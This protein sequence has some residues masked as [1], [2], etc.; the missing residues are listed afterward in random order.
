M[1][2]QHTNDGLFGVAGDDEAVMVR[3]Q[4]TQ[5]GEGD[6]GGALGVDVD[7]VV[8]AGGG[9]GRRGEVGGFDLGGVVS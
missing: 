5:G 3:E 9:G 8:D 4:R 6:V 7:V 1:A 2:P